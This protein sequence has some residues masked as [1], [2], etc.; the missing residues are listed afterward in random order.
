M[1][2]NSI[3]HPTDFSDLSGAA[4]AHALR[5]A[6]AGRSQLHLLHVEPHDI[7]GAQ[8][9]PRVRQLLV[10]WGFAGE[11]DP[12]WVIANRLGIEVDTTLLKGQEPTRGILDF[13]RDSPSH[14]TVLATRGRHGLEHWLNGS[15]SEIV[16][17]HSAAPT[18]F[19]VP[20]ATGFVSQ[21]NGEVK[22]RR[23]LVPIDFS[24]RADKAIK[25]IALMGR[26]L[27]GAEIVLH[28]LHVG[29]TAPSISAS[30]ASPTR[31]MQVM[32]RSGN[33]VDTIIDVAIEFEVDFIGMPTA[34]H[35]NILDVF[36]GSTTE[37]VIRRAPCPVIA[38]P[39]A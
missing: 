9:F 5:I 35:R 1:A 18:L 16:A 26:L 31:A 39:A 38:I 30:P 23:A 4:F 28:F 7:C 11:D 10:Q 22:L 36:R 34:G 33:V 6:L 24:P 2:I 17:R 3:L 27:T 19:I 20:G 29:H 13:L 14:L 8:A 32:L 15:V 12:P 37:R 25:T 21:I